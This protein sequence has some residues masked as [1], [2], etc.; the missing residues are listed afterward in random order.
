MQRPRKVAPA[1]APEAVRPVLRMRVACKTLMQGDGT[2][3][4]QGDVIEVTPQERANYLYWKR[5]T[6]V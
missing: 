3:H 5:A 2:F 1:A 6:D 4:E